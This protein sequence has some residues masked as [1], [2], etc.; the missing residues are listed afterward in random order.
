MP[1]CEVHSEMALCGEA[2]AVAGAG[3]EMVDGGKVGEE[4]GCWGGYAAA[5]TDGG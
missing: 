3:V 1:V 4:V 2:Y 5:G